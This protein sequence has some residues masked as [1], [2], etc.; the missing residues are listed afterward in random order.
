MTPRSCRQ[1]GEACDTDD[2]LCRDCQRQITRGGGPETIGVNEPST[3]GDAPTLDGELSGV[4][5]GSAG[6][7]HEQQNAALSVNQD[8][9]DYELL[10]EV[11]RGGMGVVYQAR[12]KRLNRVAAIKMILGG[13]FSS[14][15]DI[16][17][18]YL[19]AEAVAQLDHPG[20]VPIYEIGSHEGQPFFAMKFIE[21]GSLHEHRKRIGKS[22]RRV[23]AL[24]SKVAGA[25]HHAHQRG[26]LHRDIKPA[27]ILLDENDSPLLTDLGIAKT[28]NSDNNLTRT[29]AVLGTPSYMPPEQAQPGEALT[30]AADIYS[31]GAILFELL[32]GRPPH[33]GLTAVDTVMQVIHAPTPRPR[34][35]DAGVDRDLELICLKCLEKVPEQ[36]YDSAADLSMDLERWLRGEPISVRPPS[37]ANLAS[38][39]IRRHQGIFYTVL[40]LLVGCLF[41]VPVVFSLL[42]NL[43][44]PAGLYAGT[45]EDPRPLLFSFTYIPGWIP[46]ASALLILTLWPLLGILITLFTRPS[47]LGKATFNG[48]VVGGGVSIL[49]AIAIGWVGFMVVS[50]ATSNESI[51]LLAQSQWPYGGRPQRDVESELEKKY[52]LLEQM[53]DHEKVN[54]ISSRIF[55]DGVAVGPTVLR[56]IFVAVAFIGLPIA[57]GAV[58][59]YSL[60]LRSQ[61]WW[62]FGLRYVLGWLACLLTFVISTAALTGGNFNGR[63]LLELELWV[64]VLIILPPPIIAFLVLRRWQKPKASHGGIA[65]S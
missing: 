61:R 51:R 18:F 11:A 35:I 65:V 29:G 25:V 27:N 8:F 3:F 47:S 17:R 43:N 48:A 4:T 53:P 63:T 56:G 54:Y 30:T 31:L 26:I 40:V 10:R 59:A 22:P 5:E 41:S 46:Q 7:S 32:L 23:A 24:I 58:I 2:D 49:L 39:W 21:G 6:G 1:C 44:D 15:D 16:R 57:F 19:E 20:I 9:G 34:E 38:Q 55:A 28:A 45:P 50:Q 64:Q 14:E 13:R 60:L 42:A 36:R 37:L 62:L 52:P 33:Q 12:H